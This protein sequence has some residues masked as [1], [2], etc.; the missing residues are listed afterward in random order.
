MKLKTLFTI[1]ASSNPE[2][3]MRLL[4]RVAIVSITVIVITGGYGFYHVFSSFVIKS[5]EVD[6]TSHCRLLINELKDLM[7][8]EPSGMPVELGLHGT[9]IFAFDGRLRNFLSPFNI[10]KVKIYNKEKKIVYCTDP[11]LIGQ[12][13]TNNKRLKNALAGFVDAKMVT[14]D[15]ASDMADEP[16]R[17][18]DVVETYVPIVS[19]DKRIL[20]SF[21][22]YMNITGYREQIREGAILVTVLLAVVLSGVFGF[23]YLLISGS[24]AQLRETQSKL[25]FIAITDALT[26]IHN[27]GFLMKRGDEE[28]DRIRRSSRPLGCIMIDLDH[29]KR[30]NDTKGHVAGDIIL[31]S[32]ATRLRNSVRPYDVVGRYGGEEF[33]V[34]LPDTPFDQNVIVAKRICDQ[35][36]STAFELENETI[37]V[38]VSL[39]VACFTVADR[40]LSD[41]IKRADEGLY[42]AK[43]E[44]RDRVAWVYQPGSSES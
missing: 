23:S 7:F 39:G 13:D 5:A 33:M 25:E 17:D 8:V 21:E 22:I 20:G 32:V 38:T 12:V 42:K 24:A 29:F 35:I 43:A 10:I 18:I 3:L 11:M 19:P 41:L 15:K 9:E 6:S 28:L 40:T 26:G 36:R 1:K 44:G 2:S 30:I 14:K 34:L 27:R 4:V 16:L 37:T 31:K